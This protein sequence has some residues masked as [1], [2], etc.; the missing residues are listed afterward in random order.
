MTRPRTRSPH[1][2]EEDW[3][4]VVREL[5]LWGGWTLLYHTH[6]SRRSDPGWPDDVYGHPVQRRVVFAELKRETGIVSAAQRRWLLLLSAAGH[7]TALWYPY[8]LEEVRAVLGRQQRTAR[9]PEWLLTSD[10]V[11]PPRAGRAR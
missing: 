7:E 11:R 6:D 3:R 1:Q 2:L 9:L 4:Q 5:A 10:A 8:D